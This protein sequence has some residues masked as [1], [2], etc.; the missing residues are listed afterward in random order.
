[1]IAGMKQSRRCWMSPFFGFACAAFLGACSFSVGYYSDQEAA[2]KANVATMRQLYNSQKFA[3]ACAMVAV[4]ASERCVSDGRREFEEF[5]SYRDTSDVL[6][7]CIPYQVQLLYLSKYE[8]GDA[9]ERMVWSVRDGKAVLVQYAIRHGHDAFP[10][11]DE[12]M[13]CTK[14][15]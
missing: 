9:M 10:H 6:A 8:K 7:L 11:V 3:E 15:A 4:G 5:G 12:K 13:K 14:S 1:M 2:A